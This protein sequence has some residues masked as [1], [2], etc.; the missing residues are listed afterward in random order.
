MGPWFSLWE[1]CARGHSLW[2][3]RVCNLFKRRELTIQLRN[4]LLQHLAVARVA[5]CLQ[6]LSE[7]FPGQKQTLAFPVALL[8]AGR[9]RWADGFPLLRHF[10]LLLFYGLTLPAA[11]HLRILPCEEGCWLLASPA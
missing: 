3:R 5:G 11:C 8:F 6:L 1:V 4:R 10:L 2:C 9:D 7:A